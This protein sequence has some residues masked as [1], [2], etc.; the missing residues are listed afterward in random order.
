MISTFVT[1]AQDLGATCERAQ[2][3]ELAND[4]VRHWANPKRCFH[5]CAFLRAAI[6]RIDEFSP[7]SH[8]PAALHLAL[9]FYG[10]GLAYP[11]DPNDEFAVTA[12]AERCCEVIVR[13]LAPLGVPQTQCE[14]VCHLVQAAI[15]RSVAPGDLDTAVLVDAVLSQFASKPQDYKQLCAALRRELA[16]IPEGDYLRYRRSYLSELLSRPQ[17][18]RSPLAMVWEGQARQNIEGELASVQARLEDLGEQE[19]P[20]PVSLRRDF[21]TPT[22][23]N[24]S[25]EDGAAVPSSAVAGEVA[26]EVSG[27]V[28]SAARSG[29]ALE[30]AASAPELGAAGAERDLPSEDASAGNSAVGS[31][32]AESLAAGEPVPGNPAAGSPAA[33][34]PPPSEPAPGSPAAESLA[35]G[36]PPA[37][38]PAPEMSSLE[39]IPDLLAPVKKDAPRRLSAKEQARAA[40]GPKPPAGSN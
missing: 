12:S 32:A 10:V 37:S 3:E 15:T 13:S 36:N 30:P 27:D 16:D 4:L 40:R 20:P 9:W 19:L 28:E 11:L 31:P 8:N 25:H 26:R 17:I 21:L 23:G 22:P 33:G 39:M 5:D 38:E 34:D 1:A 6:A 29:V 18:F 35:A 14:H 7:A 24:L 2:L